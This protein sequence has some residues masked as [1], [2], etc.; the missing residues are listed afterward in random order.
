MDKD[1]EDVLTKLISKNILGGVPLNK[2]FPEL[3]EAIL[4]ATTEVHSGEEYN[5]YISTLK[6]IMSDE[7]EGQSQSVNRSQSPDQPGGGE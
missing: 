2:H 3:G 5:N 4:V 1:S 6:L 7:S